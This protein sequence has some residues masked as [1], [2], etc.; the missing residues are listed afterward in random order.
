MITRWL[1]ASSV[2]TNGDSSALEEVCRYFQHLDIMLAKLAKQLKV[3][4]V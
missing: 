4:I 1:F 2:F 3:R